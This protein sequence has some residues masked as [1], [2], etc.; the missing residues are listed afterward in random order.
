M[1]AAGWLEGVKEQMG[2]EKIRQVIQRRVIS[3]PSTLRL[4]L[5]LKAPALF[6]STSK[7]AKRR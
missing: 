4:R 5:E 1:R 2:Q 7:R 6:N 3:M